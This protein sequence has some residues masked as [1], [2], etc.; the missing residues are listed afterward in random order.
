MFDF[1]T[2]VHLFLTDDIHRK[3]QF[4][5]L[6]AICLEEQ[7][8]TIIESAIILSNIYSTANQ[9]CQIKRIE[10]KFCKLDDQ[11]SRALAVYTFQLEQ[12]L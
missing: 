10:I 5:K 8:I 4:T 1:F 7:K 3:K 11:F 12:R 2:I 9:L 6:R